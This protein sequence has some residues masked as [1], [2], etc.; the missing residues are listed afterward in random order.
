MDNLSVKKTNTIATKKTNITSTASIDCHSKKV[1]DCYILHAVLLAID[2]YYYFLSSCKTKRYNIKMENNQSKKVRIKNS[3]CYYFH[4]IIKLEDFD[5]ENILTD[6]KS[7]ENISIYNILYK[8]LIDPKPLPI[9]FDKI[10][11]MMEVDI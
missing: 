1:R 9:R 4:N 3:T 2:N 5:L 7:H 11:F 6:E 10:E 8:T